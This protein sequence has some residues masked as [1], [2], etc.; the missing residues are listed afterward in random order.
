MVNPAP[1]IALTSHP[2]SAIHSLPILAMRML[3]LT[4]LALVFSRGLGEP[5]GTQESLDC[6]E[7]SVGEGFKF[8]ASACPFVQCPEAF[9]PAAVPTLGEP[10]S[11]IFVVVPT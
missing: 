3:S 9:E 7:A 1:E 11:M 4:A 2:S 5:C 10:S 8:G 6:C